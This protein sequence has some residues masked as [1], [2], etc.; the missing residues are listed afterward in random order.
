MVTR[1]RTP[2]PA[3]IETGRGNENGSRL[4]RATAAENNGWLNADAIEKERA[5]IITADGI[6]T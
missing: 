2:A 3:D 1:R 6:S 5:E 4:T